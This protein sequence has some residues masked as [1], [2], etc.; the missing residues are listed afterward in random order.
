M[1]EEKVLTTQEKYLNHY[2]ELLKQTLQQQVLNGISLQASAKVNGDIVN[3]W[4]KENESLVQ[5]LNE[6][7]QQIE[8]L[9]AD[10]GTTQSVREQQQNTEIERLKGVIN[11]KDELVKNVAATKDDTIK[12]LQTEISRLGLVAIEYEKIKNQVQHLDTF[13]TELAKTQK[14]LQDKDSEMQNALKEKDSVIDELNKKIDYLQLTPAKRKKVDDKT[15][16]PQKEEPKKEVNKVEV[17]EVKVPEIV[18][19]TKAK[20]I[21][22]ELPN[23]VLKDGGS[24]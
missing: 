5:K 15:S 13:R 11:T 17:K 22:Q 24:F 8:K 7:A 18:K 16:S 1:S 23:L 10:V 4:Q 12:N 9:K 6:A 19:S 20:I 2:V 14:L 3:E 21:K